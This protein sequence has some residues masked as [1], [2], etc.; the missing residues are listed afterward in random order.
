MVSLRP[1][2]DSDREA[3]EALRV[4]PSQEQFVSSVAES[5][6]AAVDRAMCWAVYA[7][8]TPVGFVMISDEVGGPIAFYERYGFEQT[9]EIVFD[10]E[11]LLRLALS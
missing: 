11:V 10:D 8:E 4:S 3:V 2:T 7:D 9:G 5:L 1:S 6:L